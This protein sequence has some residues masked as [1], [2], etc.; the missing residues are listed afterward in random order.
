M[1]AGAHIRLP[2]RVGRRARQRH[3]LAHPVPVGEA[4]HRHRREPARGA[5]RAAS[6]TAGRAA[7]TGCR[8]SSWPWRPTS[9]RS[10]A[11][12]SPS[13][14][15]SACRSS[16]AA[17]S[18]APSR[19]CCSCCSRD[20]VRARS[21]SSSSGCWSIIAIGFT[22]GVFV[23]PPDPAGV[24]RRARAAVRGCRIGAARGIDP[25]R[26]D[27]AAR[28]L[29]AQRAQLATGSRRARGR[30][31]GRVAARPAEHRP[32][33]ASASRPRHGCRS[34]ARARHGDGRAHR[35]AR[36]APPDGTSR[37]PWSSPA[38]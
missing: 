4:R 38:P 25:R 30:A 34:R 19:W 28:D 37:S 23:A 14:C 1:T 17:S 26:D 20:A 15:C 29:R 31:G 12:R 10:S 7:P 9:P 18:P 11:A 33:T 36:C 6:T 3:G 24:R 5:R 27:H 2:A 32:G 35:H 16:G 13:T 22:V 8:P 21:S